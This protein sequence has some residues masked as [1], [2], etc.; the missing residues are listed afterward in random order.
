MWLQSSVSGPRHREH[1]PLGRVIPSGNL[2]VR[3]ESTSHELPE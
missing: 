3:G 1:S 2:L